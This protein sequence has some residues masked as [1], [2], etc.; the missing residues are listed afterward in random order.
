MNNEP[1]TQMPSDKSARLLQALIQIG[2]ELSSTIDLEELLDRILAVARDVFHFENAIIRLL[3]EKGER[4]VA[5]AAYGYT[6]EAMQPIRVG[7]GIMGRVARTR[8]PILVEDV[9]R[10]HLSGSCT[11]DGRHSDVR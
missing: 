5:A 4:L 11:S 3:D 1:T 2:Y 6:Q 8:Q 9:S 7:Q 10:S